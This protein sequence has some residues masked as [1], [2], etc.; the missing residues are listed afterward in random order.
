MGLFIGIDNSSNKCGVAIIDTDNNTVDLTTAERSS[1]SHI[2][3]NGKRSTTFQMNVHP[4]EIIDTMDEFL[5]PRIDTTKEIIIYLE[6]YSPGKYPK[7][8]KS[9]KVKYVK[10]RAQWTPLW[11]QG[12][13]SSYIYATYKI[14]PTYIDHFDWK[15][16]LNGK[17]TIKKEL[18][19]SSVYKQCTLNKWDMTIHYTKKDKQDLFDAFGIAFHAYRKHYEN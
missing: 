8:L 9:G 14:K 6:K 15:L 13:I 11:M 2:L 10:M 7:K 3:N 1:K 19:E 12:F 4:Y 18:V 5:R 16:T 17:Q